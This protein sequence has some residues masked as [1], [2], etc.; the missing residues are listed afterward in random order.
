MNWPG[1]SLLTSVCVTDDVYAQG[2]KESEG[3][4]AATNNTPMAQRRITN[5]RYRFVFKTGSSGYLK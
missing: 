2:T 5:S 3:S 4:A 1:R